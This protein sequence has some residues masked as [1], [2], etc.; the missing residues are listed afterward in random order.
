MNIFLHESLKM[1]M[2]YT[3][4]EDNTDTMNV[5]NNVAHM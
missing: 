4:P 1:D 5:L 3:W 2:N